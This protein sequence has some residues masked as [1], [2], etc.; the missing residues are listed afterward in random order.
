MT[1]EEK[2]EE[3]IED[4]SMYSADSDAMTGFDSE[5]QQDSAVNCALI[6]VREVKKMADKLNFYAASD[7]YGNDVQYWNEVEDL[8]QKKKSK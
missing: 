8:L 5:I 7:Y 3:L 2:A 1:P 4:F 6:A